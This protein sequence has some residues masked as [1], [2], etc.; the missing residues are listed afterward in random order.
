MLA[1]A[2]KFTLEKYQKPELRLGSTLQ[3]YVHIA[4]EAGAVL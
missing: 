1:A 2:E 3:S 4:G